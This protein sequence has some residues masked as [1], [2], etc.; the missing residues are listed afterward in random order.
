ML[1]LGLSGWAEEKGRDGWMGE[2][3]VSGV[4]FVRGRL[5]PSPLDQD[6]WT[7]SSAILIGPSNLRVD[8]MLCCINPLEF[9]LYFLNNKTKWCYLYLMIVGYKYYLCRPINL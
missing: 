9:N 6:G 1:G 5:H 4:Y 7:R 3:R 2:D 8:Q